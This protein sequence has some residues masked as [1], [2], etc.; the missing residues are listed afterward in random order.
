MKKSLIMLGAAFMATVAV[1]GMN[2]LVIAFSSTGPDRYADGTVVKDG[3]IYALVWAPT[4]AEFAG[5]NSDGTVVGDECKLVV[6]AP[7]ALDGRSQRVL[8]QIDEDYLN[9]TYPGGTWGVYLLDTRVFAVD[10]N[11]VIEKDAEGNPVVK[12]VKGKSV[13]G[14]V[15]VGESI[16]AS[17]YASTGT[18]SGLTIDNMSVANVRIERIAFEGDQVLL[19]VS[20]ADAGKYEL[21]SGDQ[22][23]TMSSD[24]KDRSGNGS[25]EAVIV[26]PKKA[27]GQFFKVNR[28]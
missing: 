28:K 12:S 19:Y 24:G 15:Q 10:E 1:A 21:L 22:V 4:G 6:K 27:G 7:S 2:N 13:K 20:D 17:A 3:E 25:G 8:F 9:A 23:D 5:F 16:E 26:C 18:T 11:G 14:W